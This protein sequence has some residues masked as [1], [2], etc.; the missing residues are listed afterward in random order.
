MESGEDSF[1]ALR[2]N[3]MRA[4]IWLAFGQAREKRKRL[5]PP[6]LDFDRKILKRFLEHPL[7]GS[8]ISH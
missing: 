5:R 7:V 2:Y 4:I 8:I 6:A 1:I 3:T